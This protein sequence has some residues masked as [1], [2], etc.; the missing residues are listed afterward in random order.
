MLLQELPLDSRTR[1]AVLRR[2]SFVVKSRTQSKI[3]KWHLVTNRFDGNA[4]VHFTPLSTSNP[5]QG[6]IMVFQVDRAGDR[7]PA[8][9]A[10]K[11]SG[12]PAKARTA[13]KNKKKK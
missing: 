13:N 10:K 8:R 4:D 7:L 11:A 9:A 5:G 6:V 3:R 12:K 1:R 2:H